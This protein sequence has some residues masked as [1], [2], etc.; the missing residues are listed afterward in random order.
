MIVPKIGTERTTAMADDSPSAWEQ[1]LLE[2]VNRARMDPAGEAAALITDAATRTGATR[3]ITLALRQYG[4][5]VAA[6]AAAM[7]T[8]DPR[9]PLAWNAAL[10][11]AAEGHTAALVRAGA[12]THQLPGELDIVGRIQA[13]GD[14]PWQYIRENVY[15]SAWSPVQAHAA[16]LIDW[17]Y[18]AGGMQDDAGHRVAIMRSAMTEIGIGVQ[19]ASGRVGPFVVTQDFGHRIDYRAQLLG[20]V[21]DDGDGD[22]FYDAGEGM[23]GVTVTATGSAGT[24]ATTTWAAGGY[25]M[26]LPAGTYTVTFSGGGLN[27]VVT[28]TITFG[29]TNLKLD[30]EADDARPPA[31]VGPAPVLGTAGADLLEGTAAGELLVGRGGADSIAG[32]AGDDLILAEGRDI[33]FDAVAGQV[34]RLYEAL[35]G[36]APDMGG[37]LTWAGRLIPAVTARAGGAEGT[38]LDW[39]LADGATRDE[40]GSVA[41]G[42][43]TSREFQTR[44]GGLDNAGFVSLLY[45]NVLGREPDTGGLAAWTGQLDRGASRASVVTGFSES[46]EFRTSA[47]IDALNQSR[48]ALQ[49]DMADDVFR[50]YRAVLGRSP[51]AAGFDAWT[52]TMAQG[53]DFGTVAQ[54]FTGS[55]E[56]QTRYGGLDDDGFVTLLYRNV[57]GRDPDAAGLAAWS[58]RL[59]GGEARS[60]VVTGFAQSREFVAATADPLKEWIRARGVDDRIDGG[61]GNNVLFGGTG[62]DTFVF[63]RGNG[64]SHHVADPEPWDRIELSGF[65]YATAAEA[66]SHLTRQG[67]DLVFADQGVSITFH[68]LRA[69]TEDMVLLA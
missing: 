17:G 46:S 61:T 7:A 30:A 43:T 35:L 62:A 50:I 23:G 36:R 52:A 33:A 27:G 34:M 69:M 58:A 53:R 16:F 55:R 59:A 8:Y 3:E 56:F 65:G 60:T 20:V 47:R 29:A 57:L 25:Q 13:Q 15:S 64:G 22:D 54:G 42:L 48:A 2:L 1:E 41:Q 51:D 40:I 28:Q 49:A 24:Y 4:V 21:I 26:E 31:P 38:G 18:G 11:R 5:D 63:A 66:L 45:R 68:D 32:A 14:E 10:S 12:Q 39:V 6:F 19:A 67:D 9:V 37:L 44:Y